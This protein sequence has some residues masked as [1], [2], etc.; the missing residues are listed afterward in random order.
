MV[1]H[2]HETK[3]RLLAKLVREL[4]TSERFETLADLTDALK[5]RCSKLKISQTPAD[6]TEAFRVI[7]SN[8]SLANEPA[9][10][11][12]RRDTT[13]APIEEEIIPRVTA[14]RVYRE[15]M[16]RYRSEQAPIPR[17]A[18]LDRPSD[19]PDLVPV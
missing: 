16:D 5:A 11:E 14:S 17:P 18:Q 13:P 7:A 1:P 19:F 6:V 10:L 15:L 4:L 12:R 9:G 3:S 8:T 2:D